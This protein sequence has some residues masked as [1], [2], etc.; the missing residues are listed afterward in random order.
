MPS[1]ATL[2]PDQR[3]AL[4]QLLQTRLSGLERDRG[5]QLQGLTQAEAARQT[6]LQDADDAAQR[7]SAHEVEAIV[8][9]LDS[10]EYEQTRL[11]LQRIHGATY[12]RCADCAAAIPF[13]RLQIEPQALRCTA[14]QKL[15]EAA[16]TS[17]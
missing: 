14:C 12:G 7:A 4:L 5:A 17:P 2:T 9:D 15:Q 11:A 8:S 10:A 6:L 13:A 1:T 3:S 16:T